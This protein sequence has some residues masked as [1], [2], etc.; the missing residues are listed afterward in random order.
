MGVNMDFEQDKADKLKHHRGLR[1][2]NALG[3]I[4]WCK[5]NCHKYGANNEHTYCEAKE[6]IRLLHPLSWL[7]LFGVILGAIVLY[8]I[9]EV[10]KEV[11]LLIRDET[12]WW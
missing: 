5:G 2:M 9:V 4:A 7:W 3:M 8:G 1:V 12:V 11:K 6:K 10:A